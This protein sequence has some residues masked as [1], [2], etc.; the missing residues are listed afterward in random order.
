MSVVTAWLARWRTWLGSRPDAARRFDLVVIDT[1]TSGLDVARDRLLAIGAVAVRD[2]VL[3]S[4]DCFHAV[5]RQ[6]APKQG[7][8][9][10]IHRIGLDEQSAGDPP[11]QVLAAFSAWCAGRWAVAYHA[12]FDR[13]MLERA[14]REAGRP[15]PDLRGWID[16]AVL[17]PALLPDRRVRGRRP[18][19]LDDWLES[20]GIDG[21]DRHD[22]LGDALA[23]AQ[24][25]L[26]VL[27]AARARAI[28]DAR[29]LAA[30]SHAAG[31]LRE[32][33]R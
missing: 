17:A 6:P 29:A 10:L 3:D 25:L 4:A 32:L 20:W 26:P 22:A 7:P 12:D 11:G 1:E 33:A 30:E 5:L 2:G 13:R 21:V 8:D 27:H 31:R 15:P 18:A 19:S 16:L 24:L 9:I 14:C 28:H 23:T